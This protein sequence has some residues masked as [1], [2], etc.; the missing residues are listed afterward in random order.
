MV[1]RTLPD[2]GQMTTGLS[3]MEAMLTA[4]DGP[5]RWAAY[6]ADVRALRRWYAR[7]VVPMSTLGGLLVGF[8]AATADTLGDDLWWLILAAMLGL[9]GT[10]QWG[11]SVRAGVAPMAMRPRHSVPLAAFPICYLGGLVA[12]HVLAPTAAL[13]LVT[14]LAIAATGWVAAILELRQPVPDYPAEWRPFIGT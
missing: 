5:A 10:R 7:Q 3:M 8:Y 14:G 6:W 13:G 9:Y 11:R 12:P 1:R 2:P 4:T